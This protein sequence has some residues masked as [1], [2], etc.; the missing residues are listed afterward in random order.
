MFNEH[1]IATPLDADVN[2]T[3]IAGSYFRFDQAVSK[4]FAE[5]AF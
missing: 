3:H 5:D 1:L 4:A 2:V